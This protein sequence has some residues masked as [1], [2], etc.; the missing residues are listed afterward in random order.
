MMT[1]QTFSLEQIE[2]AMQDQT[3]FCIV[4]G[5]EQDNCEPDARDYCCEDCD[6]NSVYGA[7]EL[8]LMGYVG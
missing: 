8:A 4:C 5:Y 3:G 6:C 1:K 2:Q 7:E